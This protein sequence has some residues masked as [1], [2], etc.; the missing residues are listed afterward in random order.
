M[1]TQAGQ[2]I[3]KRQ[4]T[5]TVKLLKWYKRFIASDCHEAPRPFQWGSYIKK[6]EAQ[7]ELTRLINVS[8]NRKAGIPDNPSKHYGLEFQA[9]IWRDCQVIQYLIHRNNP[10]YVQWKLNGKVWLGTNYM[11]KR[12]GHLSRNVEDEG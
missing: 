9:E 5:G 4:L 1:L 10:T 7:R 2:E 12:Y 11:Q 8:I 6:P 3:T